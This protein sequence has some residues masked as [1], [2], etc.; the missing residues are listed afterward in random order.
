MFELIKLVC[1]ESEISGPKEQ[2]ITER[3]TQMH[4]QTY[5]TVLLDFIKS[6]PCLIMPNW[7]L[8]YIGLSHSHVMIANTAEKKTPD[9]QTEILKPI[10]YSRHHRRC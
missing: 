2:Q 3:H 8:T 4:I 9:I 6:I 1:A 5:A 7:H 10:I